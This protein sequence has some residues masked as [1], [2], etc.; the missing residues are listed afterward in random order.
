MIVVLPEGEWL[1]LAGARVVERGGESAAPSDPGPVT[2]IFPGDQVTVRWVDLPPMPLPQASAAAR[3]LAA[4]FAADPLESLHVAAGIPDA[5]G[6]RP[7]A[8]VRASRLAAFVADLEERGFPPD[9]IVPEPFLLPA[10]P[11]GLVAHER[12][13]VLLVRGPETAA[14]IDPDL[15][16]ALGPLTRATPAEFEAG[17]GAALL[18]APLDLRQGAFAL[19]QGW[20]PERAFI[21]RL[22]RMAAALALLSL[23]VPLTEIVKLRRATARDTAELTA[24]ARAALPPAVRIANAPAQL[25]ERMAALRGG[26]LGY[27]AT[28]GAIFAAIAAT[29]ESRLE[30]VEYT[31][32]GAANATLSATSAAHLA[33]VANRVRL[34]GFTTTLGPARSEGGRQLAD[35]Q[36]TPA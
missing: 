31:A 1:R 9:S 36:V 23:A 4:D 17:L 14:A 15:A 27:S 19:R 24:V 25:A 33:S 32:Q 10:P 8:L 13:G 16:E 30:S 20:R 3:L 6:R 7:V 18:A 28:V 2:A 29:P 21:R 12:G 35:L 26:G 22:A 11:Q 34:S 5:S